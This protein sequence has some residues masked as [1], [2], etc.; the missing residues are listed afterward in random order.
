MFPRCRILYKLA[1]ACCCCGS[2]H[3]PVW[4]LADEHRCARVSEQG[5][6]LLTLLKFCRRPLAG[7]QNN[8]QEQHK[9][10]IQNYLQGIRVMVSPGKVN[11]EKPCHS[12]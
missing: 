5:S 1:A 10:L 3:L 8:S 9:A 6:A 7:I 2:T 12:L 11:S 4:D